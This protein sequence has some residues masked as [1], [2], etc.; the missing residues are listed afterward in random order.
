V[1]GRRTNKQRSRIIQT[2][3]FCNYFFILA[4]FKGQRGNIIKC[5]GI[6]R[7]LPELKMSKGNT[8][9]TRVDKYFTHLYCF[10]LFYAHQYLV[11]ATRSKKLV[12][13]T[14]TTSSGAKATSDESYFEEFS[15]NK[16]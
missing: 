13:T 5:C 2:K 7:C 12:T 9:A 10:Q 1:N 4:D 11:N 14:T 3:F 15:F 8:S 16:I 6:K